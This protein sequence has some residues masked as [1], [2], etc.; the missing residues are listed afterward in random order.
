MDS[1]SKRIE[2]IDAL[3]AFALFGILIVHT[4]QLFNFNNDNNDL[5]YFTEMGCGMIDYI[6]RFLQ[7][8]FVIIFSILF[9]TSFYFILKNPNYSRKR[10]CWRCSLL[11]A[12]GLINKLVYTTDILVWYGL[13]GI[14]L[15]LLPIRRLPAKYVF[16]LAA[17]FYIVSF[18]QSFDL[19]DIVSPVSE[20]THRYLVSEGCKGIITYSYLEVIKEDIHIFWELGTLTLSYFLFGYFLGKS[21][22][23]ENIDKIATIK[24]VVMFFLLLFMVKLIYIYTGYHPNIKKILNFS[25]SLSYS[26]FFLFV[27]N[28]FRSYLSFLCAYGKLGLTHYSAQ[29]VILPL[30][31]ACFLVHTKLSFEY[32]FSFSLFFYVIQV[33]FSMLWLKKYCFGPLEYLWR[34]LTNCRYI[35]NRRRPR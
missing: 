34:V 11:V 1:S 6:G 33:F 25:A 30:F 29:N 12:F 28:Q 2:S 19:G 15:G 4:S 32:I 17:I 9:G 18:Q 31:V 27:F 3:R 26:L 35:S 7:N 23:I 22:I 20:Y 8:R 21:H 16:I 24:A 13:N 10:F 5:S 14:I